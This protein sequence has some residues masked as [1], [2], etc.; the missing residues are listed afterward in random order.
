MWLADAG[1]QKRGGCGRSSMQT[2]ACHVVVQNRSATD[3]GVC[4]FASRPDGGYAPK[5][6]T[7]VSW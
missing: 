6:G 3:P 4:F 1:K 2:L 7:K 5:F